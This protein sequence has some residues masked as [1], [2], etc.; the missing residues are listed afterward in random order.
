MPRPHQRRASRNRC[1]AHKHTQDRH[2]CMMSSTLGML[3]RLLSEKMTPGMSGGLFLFNGTC[4]IASA[5][6]WFY[7]QS[8]TKTPSRPVGGKGVFTIQEETHRNPK[9]SEQPHRLAYTVK[10][11]VG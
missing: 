6:K 8:E 4:K 3:E 11:S 10:L 9:P 1:S 5:W 2:T 7:D